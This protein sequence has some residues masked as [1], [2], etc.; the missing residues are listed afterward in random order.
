MDPQATWNE[1]LNA[2]VEG[3]F[4]E[5]GVKADDLTAWLDRGG[6][7][8]QP[9]TRVLSDVWDTMI[10]RFVCRM[11]LEHAANSERNE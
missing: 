9:L 2:M 6:F 4:E 8:P 5:A 1:M 3:D 10:C 7:P 11:V